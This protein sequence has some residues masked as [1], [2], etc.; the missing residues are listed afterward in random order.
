VSDATK[1]GELYA[2]LAKDAY[3]PF[4]SMVAKSK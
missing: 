1:L 2:E 4:E 3:K